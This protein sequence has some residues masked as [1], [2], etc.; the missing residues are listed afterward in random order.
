MDKCGY[1]SH[2]FLSATCAR[3]Y[4]LFDVIAREGQADVRWLPGLK[5]SL[6]DPDLAFHH[7]QL[8]VRKWGI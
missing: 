7:T 4:Y 5:V 3:A 8:L 2:L 1:I 6:S